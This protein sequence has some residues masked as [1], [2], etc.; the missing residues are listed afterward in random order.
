M[1][2]SE[3]PAHSGPANEILALL[4]FSKSW[5]G[6]GL[7]NGALPQ[8]LN[9]TRLLQVIQKDAQGPKIGLFIVGLAVHDFWG[10]V[11]GRA[12]SRGHHLVSDDSGQSE[13]CDFVDRGLVVGAEQNVL[14]LL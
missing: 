9:F 10:Q 11:G 5:S 6:W 7:V 8:S 13:I 1:A 14:R 12:A 3:T 4:I 2:I